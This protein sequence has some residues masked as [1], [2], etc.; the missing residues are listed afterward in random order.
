MSFKP[1]LR[2]AF[3]RFDLRNT[4]TDFVEQFRR[5]RVVPASCALA[6]AGCAPLIF[7]S[8][9]FFEAIATSVQLILLTLASFHVGAKA[10]GNRRDLLLFGVAALAP[11]VTTSLAEPDVKLDQLVI[12]EGP[13]TCKDLIFD[14]Y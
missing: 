8:L 9:A 6:R 4:G 12:L 7:E 10:R 14:E 2:L 1:S 13:E 11:L 3:R 5:P